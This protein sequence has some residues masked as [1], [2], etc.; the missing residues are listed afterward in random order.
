MGSKLTIEPTIIE[1]VVVIRSVRQADERGSFGRWFCQ[2][3]LTPLLQGNSIRQINH[4]Q[5]YRA[6][7]TRGLHFQ[8]PPAAEYKLVR[9]IHGI[10][11]DFVVDLRADSASFLQHI[12]IELK[13]SDDRMV[14]IPPGCAHGFQALANNSQLL[15]L[16]TADYQ[17]GF[18][19]GVQIADPLLKINLPLP[20]SEI[21]QRDM[22]FPLLS[23]DFP[24]INV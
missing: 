14:L 3:E 9:C 7:V 10:V 18:E 24:G 4:S 13:A 23:P 15:Y 5:N 12:S 17:P 20:I 21:S 22:N 8:Y 19:G 16:H 2:N 6:G 1:G 11:Q